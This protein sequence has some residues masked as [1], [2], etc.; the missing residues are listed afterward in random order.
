MHPALGYFSVP[1]KRIKIEKNTKRLEIYKQMGHNDE[2]S[3]RIRTHHIV[4]LI[5]FIGCYWLKVMAL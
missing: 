5:H 4:V 3:V 1:D 2:T